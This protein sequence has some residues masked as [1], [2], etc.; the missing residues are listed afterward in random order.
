MFNTKTASWAATLALQ[1]WCVGLGFADDGSTAP[2]PERPAQ[3]RLRNLRGQARSLRLEADFVQQRLSTLVG[4]RDRALQRLM[5]ND[6]D[7]ALLAQVE[8]IFAE[9][10]ARLLSRLEYVQD[11]LQELHRTIARRAALADLPACQAESI[12]SGPSLKQ[13]CKESP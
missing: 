7:Q 8:Q 11:R 1:V 3:T 5:L 9:R 12:A 10:E 13:N 2:S 6:L 4:Q